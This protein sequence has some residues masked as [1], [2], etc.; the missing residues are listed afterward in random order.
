L[1]QALPQ[2][3]RPVGHVHAVPLHTVVGAAHTAQLVPQ[4]FTSLATHAAPDEHWCW[5][6]AQLPQ[7]PAEHDPPGHAV[8]AP[9]C[10]A[11]PQV[12]RVLA[13][14]HCVAFGAQTPAHAPE[15]HAWSVHAT[16]APHC[17]A[18]LHV[19][20]PLVPEHCVAPG[21]HVPAQAP[22]T[23]A[24]PEQAT[25]APHCPSSPHVSTPLVPEHCVT[26]GAQTPLQPPLT[27]A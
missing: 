19:S 7:T 8:S 22:L 23:H 12:S 18:L 17:P 25:A 1:T 9:H 4:A 27:H 20:T 24:W 2:S 6:A 13:L 21:E 10:P 14:P 5:P 26:F 11:A 16:G 15:T 3:D